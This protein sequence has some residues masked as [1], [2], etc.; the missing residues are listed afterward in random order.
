M[1]RRALI[2]LL[3]LTLACS[4]GTAHAQIVN[5]LRAFSDSLGWDAA[6]EGF[7]AVASGNSE[8][9]EFDVDGAA[10]YR[11]ERHRVRFL[12]EHTRREAE[13]N[14]IA[15]NTLIHVRHNYVLWQR[16]AT[17][18]FGQVQRNP[19]RR[20]ERRTL[21]G[22]GLRYDAVAGAKFSAALGATVMY[23]TEE[24]TDDDRG[25]VDRA[26]MSYFASALG[27]PRSGVQVDVVAFY[28]PLVDDYNAV[29]AY[30]AAAL[31]V[32]IVGGL[33]LAFAYDLVH[34]SD[35]PAGVEPT[36]QRFRSGLG[37]KL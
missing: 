18:A 16:I 11:S 4:L 31:R 6:V 30:A 28:Q 25:A 12:G 1:R 13:G 10:Q 33:Y 14:E 29:R 27:Q 15:R 35:P 9:L 24:L 8:Y 37:W 5:T 26:R 3:P 20:V 17:V 2:L 32:D 34:D 23:E 19:F 7:L 22:G 36:D 21:L